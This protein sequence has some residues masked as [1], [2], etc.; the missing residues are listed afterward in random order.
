MHRVALSE[1]T[2]ELVSQSAAVLVGER[3]GEVCWVLRR[4]LRL[5]GT[6]AAHAAARV[7]VPDLLIEV[8]VLDRVALDMVRNRLQKLGVSGPWESFETRPAE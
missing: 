1:V 2:A 5:P 6:Y 8:D 3:G 7:S 4:N